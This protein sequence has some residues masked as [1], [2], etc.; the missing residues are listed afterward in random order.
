VS[1][2]ENADDAQPTTEGQGNEGNTGGGSPWADL[3][4]LAPEDHRGT[5]EERFREWDAN[6]TRT[7]QEASQYRSQW[8]PFEQAGLNQ[9]DPQQLA[10]HL[11]MLQDPD[12][13][14]AWVEQ[15]YGAPPQPEP[16]PEPFDPYAPDPNAQLEQ[17][18]QRQLQPLQAQVEQ[19]SQWREQQEAQAREQA[20]RESTT[21]AIAELQSKHEADIPDALKENF[22][23]LISRFSLPYAEEGGSAQQAIERGWQDFQNM[24]NQIEKAAL[25][26]KVDA[27]SPAEGGGM[28][29]VSPDKLKWGKQV[30]DTALEAL[31]SM[32]QRQ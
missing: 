11:Q 10:E 25:Q 4:S 7:S 29:D 1:F 17:L 8:Q 21:Q 27:P 12:A 2:T 6:Y 31:R 22:Q 28:A 15:T 24:V 20:A 9:Y 14:R 30:Q 19:F 23:E 26:A 32:N 3:L 16:A 18:L 5:F 13:V